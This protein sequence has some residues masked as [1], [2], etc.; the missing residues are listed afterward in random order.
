M[1]YDSV[2]IPTPLKL[3]SGT[4]IVRRYSRARKL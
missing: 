1:G 4:R 3:W 2:P